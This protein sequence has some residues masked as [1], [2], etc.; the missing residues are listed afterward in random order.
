M[1]F[2]SNFKD[3]CL[4]SDAI[5]KLMDLTLFDLLYNANYALG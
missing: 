5:I 2:L 1:Y 4:A 3:D